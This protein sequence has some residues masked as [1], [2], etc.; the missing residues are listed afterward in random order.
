MQKLNAILPI[1]PL[2]WKLE[3]NDEMFMSKAT[4]KQKLKCDIK[5]KT[6]ALRQFKVDA[7]L[8]PNT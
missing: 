8:Q 1:T 2:T 6:K 5:P 4:K 3:T 7:V